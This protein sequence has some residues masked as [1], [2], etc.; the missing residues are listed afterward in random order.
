MSEPRIF[1]NIAA[2]RDTECQWTVKDLF[3]KAR[4]PERIFVGLCWQFVPEEDQDCFLVPSPR[5]EQTRIVE[6]DANKSLGACWA[7]HHAEKLWQGE[8]Y[9]L[10]IDSHMR[11]APDWDD[12]LLDHS[13]TARSTWAVAEVFRFSSGTR[14]SIT[15]NTPSARRL[16]P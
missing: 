11:F 1:V 7:R 13:A 8:E 15:L 10:Q 6:F 16:G 3:E 12:R 9:Y 14:T 2:Y 5:P 4:A